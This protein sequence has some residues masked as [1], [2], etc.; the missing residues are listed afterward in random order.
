MKTVLVPV[1][2]GTEEIELMCIVDVLRRAGARVT[3]AA[4]SNKTIS[5]S[6]R[7]SINADATMDE[8]LDK[9][10]DLIAIPGGMPGAEAIRDH[11]GFI[12]LLKKHVTAGKL[13]A[14]VC[15]SP[16]V[17]LHTHGLIGNKKATCHPACAEPLAGN[18][19]LNQRVVVDGNLITSQ[20]PG[21]SLEFALKLAEI[22]ISKEIADKI[23]SAM[24]V[25]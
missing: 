9:E 23:R 11:A 4:I 18:P 17:V 6:R 25:K 19:G 3:M 20:A 13:Y 7:A 12:A 1:A 10:Y 14:A 15:A 24:L 8:C 16:A 22:L 2:D 21:T 5:A